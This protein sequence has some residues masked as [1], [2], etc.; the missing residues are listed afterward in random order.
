MN[1]TNE[2]KLTDKA[3]SHAIISSII[4]ILIC[5]ICICTATWAWFTDSE[6]F[7]GGTIKAGE[8]LL[9]IKVTNELGEEMQD[10]ENGVNLVAN[11]TYT[12]TLTLPKNS[13]S[14]YCKIV[15]DTEDYYSDYILNHDSDTPMVVTFQVKAESNQQVK[16]VKRWGI[17]SGEIDVASGETLVLPL[18]TLNE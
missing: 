4:G 1:N 15:T 9:E 2:K 13:T 8:C 18:V 10:L 14:G 16:F 12:V 7:V 5:L 6:D 17:Y 11:Q 3:F